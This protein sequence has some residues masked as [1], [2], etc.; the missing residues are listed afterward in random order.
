MGAYRDSVVHLE[1]SVR[2]DGEGKEAE[3]GDGLVEF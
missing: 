2:R 1:G 3:R